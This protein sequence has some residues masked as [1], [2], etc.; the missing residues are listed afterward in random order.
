MRE[1]TYGHRTGLRVC[2]VAAVLFI[3]GCSSGPGEEGS[4]PTGAAE[5]S[6]P[7][8]TSTSEVSS[9]SEPPSEEAD[10]EPTE[11]DTAPQSDT[12]AL[13]D[14]EEPEPSSDP[15]T[16]DQPQAMDASDPVSVSIPEIDMESDLMDLGIQDDGKVEVPPF[17]AGSPAGWYTHGP[18]PGETGPS[19][20]LGHLNA[21][22]GGPGIFAQLPEVEIGDSIEVAR[23]DGSIARFTVYRTDQFAKDEFPTLDVYGNTDEAE[24]RL[25]TCDN[26]NQ[27]TGLLEDNVVVYATL[28]T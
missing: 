26:L 7:S 13:T 15:E 5:T 1:V 23:D 27:D 3:T 11:D 21:M 6:A 10:T 24:L 9:N 8:S 16:P 19:V 12:L 4:N 25:I 22:G 20:L 2:A 14:S 18:T 28:E 17:E